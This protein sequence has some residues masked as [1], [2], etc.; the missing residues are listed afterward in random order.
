MQ[1]ILFTVQF[2]FHCGQFYNFSNKSFRKI[3][4][5]VSG[6]AT[7]KKLFDLIKLEAYGQNKLKNNM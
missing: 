4:N 2:L 1:T 5:A 7:E 3:P 6:I